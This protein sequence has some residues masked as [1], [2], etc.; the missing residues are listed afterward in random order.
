MLKDS[1]LVHTIGIA[2]LLTVAY[3][4]GKTTNYS[5][6]FLLIASLIYLL[7]SL[8]ADA[9]GKF[10]EHRLRLRGD[11]AVAGCGGT[12]DLS[13][14]E[15]RHGRNHPRSAGPAQIL[16]QRPGPQRHRPARHP[17]DVCV[18]IGPSG[19]GKSTLLRCLNLLETYQQGRVLLRGNVVSE[20]R[21]ESHQP[22]KAEQHQAQLLRRRVGMVFQQFNLFPH[23]NVL[24][25]VMT[26]PLQVLGKTRDESAHIAERMLRKVGLWDFHPCDPLTLSGGQQQ[27]VAIARALAMDPEIMLFDEVTSAL[28][29]QLVQEVLR[30]LRE[31]VF[32]DG[33]TM[34]VVTH[35]MD[36]ARDVAD[37]IVFLDHGRIGAQ[38]DAATI[39][40]ERPTD[41]LRAF[42]GKEGPAGNA[43]QGVKNR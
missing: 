5:G 25:N 7:M 14:V 41:A 21:P 17:R 34:L 9:L 15:G 39:L 37:Q 16:W 40:D 26:G 38:G 35:D 27:R 4:A 1:S 29:P 18:L 28:D 22:T 12:I 10:L 30:V 42:L 3:N 20:G 23:L 13:Q 19:C 32:D 31:L 8:A 6:L 2:E 24:Q 33:M 11:R 36:F 43:G